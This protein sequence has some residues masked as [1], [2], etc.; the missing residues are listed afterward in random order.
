VIDL[1]ALIE[2]EQVQRRRLV[3]KPALGHDCSLTVLDYTGLLVLDQ[4]VDAPPLARVQE[5]GSLGDD[6][7]IAARG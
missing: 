5:V 4:E 1:T 3:A 7:E 6:Q 2:E